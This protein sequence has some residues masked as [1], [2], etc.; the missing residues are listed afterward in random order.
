MFLEPILVEPCSVLVA[1][2]RHTVTSKGQLPAL[3]MLSRNYRSAMG[4]V[5]LGMKRRAK[6]PGLNVKLPQLTLF[7][8]MQR[9][10]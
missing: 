10:K 1:N 8:S 9:L 7:P 6:G 5:I 4:N 3:E 2:L